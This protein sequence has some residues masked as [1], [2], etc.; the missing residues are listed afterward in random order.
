MTTPGDQRGPRRRGG[1]GASGGRSDLLTLHA[2][3]HDLPDL[4]VVEDPQVERFLPYP[5]RL[6]RVVL[7]EDRD[8]PEGLAFPAGRVE[9]DAGQSSSSADL[10]P[11]LR[12]RSA[13]PVSPPRSPREKT[14]AAIKPPPPSP[15]A[16]PGIRR[17]ARRLRVPDKTAR[18]GYKLLIKPSKDSVRRFKERLKQEWMALKGHGI[19]EVPKRLNPILRGWANYYRT[20]VSK[21]TFDSLDHW[22][23]NRCVRYVKFAHPTKPWRWHRSKYWGELN[24]N[25]KD[26]WVFGD[27][28]TGTYLLKLSWT[29][30]ERHVLVKGRA[31]PDDPTLRGYW[32]RR[33]RRKIGTLPPRLIGLAHS[34]R[35]RCVHCGA[36]LYNGEAL[37]RHHLHPKSEGGTDQRSNLRLV[38]LYCHQQIH[39]QRK[40]TSDA[41]R[42]A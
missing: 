30:I 25:R 42:F 16:P 5:G 39:S 10:T 37:H 32:T 15:Q 21:Q 22:M 23:F 20:G 7:D 11:P 28:S 8:A 31:S 17:A 3:A 27:K 40:T 6:G 14:G 34:Q 13:L 33:E 26:R 36:S 38:H 12:A 29:P 4:V 24:P 19:A 35:G 41:K 9:P 18:S 2:A 1:R